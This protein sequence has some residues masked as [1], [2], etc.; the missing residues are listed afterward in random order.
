ME[1]K[2]KAA[3]FQAGNA[4]LAF[5]LHTHWWVDIDCSGSH[6]V[7]RSLQRLAL[8]A[9]RVLASSEQEGGFEEHRYMHSRAKSKEK[10]RHKH[11]QFC[12]Q[13]ENRV[14]QLDEITVLASTQVL[15]QHIFEY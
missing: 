11:G 8:Q 15:S 7:Q 1:L 4:Q 9:V 5:V 10:S 13:T 12:G 2:H 3:T 6:K 14:R